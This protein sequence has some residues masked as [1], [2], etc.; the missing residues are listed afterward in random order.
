MTTTA[1]APDGSN[2]QMTGESKG[3]SNLKNPPRTNVCKGCALAFPSKNKLFKH[4]QDTDGIC[5]K[6]DPQEYANY[7]KYVRKKKKLDKV[8]ILFGYLPVASLIR[9]GTDAA[10]FLIHAME[11]WQ[12]QQEGSTDIFEQPDESERKFNRSYGHEQRGVDIV[13][14]DND[15]GAITEVLSVKLQPLPPN[16]TVDNLLDEV[17]AI[18]NAQFAAEAAIVVPIRILGRQI[19]KQAK[20]SAEMDSTNR[21][22]EYVLPMDFLSWCTPEIQDRLEALPSFSE[23]NKHSIGTRLPHYARGSCFFPN[24]AEK[25]EDEGKQVED[26]P[27][28]LPDVQVLA[29]LHK[30][31]KLMQSLSTQIVQ[32]DMNDKAAVMEKGFSLQKRRRTKRSKKED[33]RAQDDGE[34]GDDGDNDQS[35]TPNVVAKHKMLKRKRFHNFTESVMAHEYLAYRRLDR[36]YHRACL[37]FPEVDPTYNKPFLVVS[38]TGDLFLTGQVLRVIGLFL[39]IANGLIDADIV[40][41]VFDEEYPHLIPTPPVLPLGMMA[42]EANYMTW[43]GKVKSILTARKTDRYPNGWN[44]M[45]TLQRVKD[46]QEVVYREI[47]RRWLVQGVDKESGRL[48]AEKEWT[49]RVLK[50]WAKKANEQLSA[51][52][53]WK[54]ESEIAIGNN[55]ENNASG[56]QKFED[57]ALPATIDATVPE[58][59]E[60]VLFHLRKIDE[61]AQWPSTTLK[62]QLVMVSTNKDAKEDEK[63]ESLSMAHMKAKNN[64]ETR[65]SAYSFA[66]GQGG[67]SGSFS[68]GYM[69][70]GINKQPK[71][72]SLF[73]ELVQAAFELETKLFPNRASS[74]IA[75]N[76]NAQFRPHTDSGAGAGQSTSLIVG[77]GTYSGGEL[78]VEGEQHDI[79]YKAIEFNGWTERHW[80]MPFSGERYSLV[81]FT[82]KGCEG[83]RGIDIEFEQS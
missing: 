14:Q 1:T 80:T 26:K 7:C 53:T 4:L 74:T 75:I 5:L 63:T 18:L 56:E 57:P 17:Q 22:V 52:R 45:S 21:R 68:V 54:T 60:K 72:N 78:M 40:D 55:P 13:A 67:A 36:M 15:T 41:C 31:K 64:K 2:G 35:N 61:T 24:G 3:V 62:R 27:Q 79:R 43:E 51:Y 29:Y 76:R 38:L 10:T 44:Q 49:E 42:G 65:S 12:S 33:S 23:N 20:F 70:G 81:W 19:M 39:S 58:L 25:K 11:E 71:S 73:P 16:I 8:L 77:L 6:D 30:L 46:W 66:E 69:P 37:R 28:N 47:A 82:P 83:M 59:F 9:N 32:L 50:P 48:V 34:D